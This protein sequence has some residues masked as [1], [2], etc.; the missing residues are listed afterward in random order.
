MN[1]VQLYNDEVTSVAINDKNDT[2]VAGFKDGTVKILTIGQGDFE[3]RESTLMFSAI[4]ARK[5]TVTQVKMNPKNGA[6]FASSNNGNFRLLRT[7][8]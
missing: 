2:L 7:K 5:G 4:G 6:L 8:V 1:V 3:T